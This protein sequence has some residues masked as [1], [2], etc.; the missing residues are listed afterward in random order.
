M[1]PTV[2]YNTD[3]RRLQTRLRH[4]VR[5]Y[6]DEIMQGSSS[7][8]SNR[9]AAESAR[10]ADAGEALCQPARDTAAGESNGESSIVPDQ[11]HIFPEEDTADQCFEF[12]SLKP[13]QP[14]WRSLDIIY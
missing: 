9:V 11:E 7:R 14:S 13:Q 8:S 5:K 2:D 4:V 6:F 3:G 12:G 1:L 10:L